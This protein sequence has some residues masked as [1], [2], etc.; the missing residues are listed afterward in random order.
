MRKEQA[1]RVCYDL[2]I[3]MRDGVILRGNLYAPEDAAPGPVILL[4][5]PY[6]K[7]SFEF[8]WGKLNPLPLA[9]AG[10]RVLLQDL[11]GTGHSQ[12]EMDFDGPCQKRDGYDT[13]EWIAAQP[14]CDGNVGMYGLSYYG[15]TQLLTAETRPPHLKAIAPWMQTGLYKYRGGFTTGSLHLMW[16]LERC[17][18]RLSGDYCT[19]PE[20]DRTNALRQVEHYLG[21]FPQV[22]GYPR[23][24]DNPAAKIPELPLLRDY[25]RR[26]AECDDPA[27]MAR[28]GR[29]IDFDKIDIPCFFLGGWYDDTSK[30]GPIENWMAIQ[31][32][33][34]GQ[35]R[36]ARCAMVMG[37]WNHGEAMPDRVGVRAFGA[38]AG[39]PMGRSV[40][41]QLIRFFDRYLKGEDNGW[42]K[43][44]PVKYF[45]MGENAWHGAPQWPLPGSAERRLYLGGSGTLEASCGENGCGSYFSDPAK[46]VPARM[47]GI[48]SECQ[49]QSYAEA[50]ED[51]AV[52]TSAPLR[53]DL[54]VVGAVKAVL[55][56]SSDCPDTDIVCK[57]TQVLPNG[58]SINLTDGAV[59]VSYNNGWSRSFLTPGEVRR[60]EVDMGN[61]GNLFPAGSRVRLDI[62][63]SAFPKY[64]RNHHVA[65]R[66]GSTEQW[67]VSHDT[68]HFGR[69]FPSCLILTTQA[70]ERQG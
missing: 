48:N 62:S 57:L 7:D 13:V 21:S 16:L 30:N 31:S 15:F 3:P 42:D 54:Q 19:M 2:E 37:P 34:R 46:P 68:L 56:V 23:E 33:P 10:Y 67:A 41:D 47:P 49:E 14:W 61:T 53:E 38:A 4:R 45:L 36:I 11:R 70:T 29:P 59:R 5:F 8:F 60:V 6:L 44:A 32:G 35:E 28:E 24:D 39:Y 69:D 55:Y 65:A 17:R 51:V 26:V 40:S 1:I 25:L 64:D 18:D 63:G 27:T 50:R 9:R 22:V 20:P 52:Y 43:E 66:V 58:Q 12:G